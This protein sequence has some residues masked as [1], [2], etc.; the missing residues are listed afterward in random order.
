MWL[1]TYASQYL[2]MRLSEKRVLEASK[3]GAE[4]LAVA[5]PL[6]LLRFEDA[7]KTQGLEHRLVVKDILE[8][9]VD[10]MEGRVQWTQ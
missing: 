4:I 2:P 8:L 10:A 6:D 3:T 5:C 9:V 1:D 7:I